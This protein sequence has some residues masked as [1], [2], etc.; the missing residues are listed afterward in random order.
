M[1]PTKWPMRLLRPTRKC[2][3]S[4]R[5]FGLDVIKSPGNEKVQMNP[6]LRVLLDT[7]AY[8]IYTRKYGL[9]R[10]TNA[11]GKKWIMLYG[12]KIVRDELRAI[13]KS[14]KEENKSFRNLILTTY[15]TLVKDH[16]YQTNDIIENLAQQYFEAYRGSHSKIELWNDFLI[17][18]CASIHNLTVLVTEDQRT[19]QSMHALAAYMIIN[20][21]ND[22]NMP[23]FY[24]TD[25][26]EQLLKSVMSDTLI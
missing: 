21:K 22:F 16:F 5:R 13:P 15:D 4:L 6:P 20:Q 10:L 1:E 25:R 14:I 17:V 18:A 9:D 23:Q 12:F 26:F 19:M 24:S 2:K 7:N 3:N 11:I 8:D